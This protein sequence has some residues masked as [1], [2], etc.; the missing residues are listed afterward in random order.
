MDLLGTHWYLR[1]ANASESMFLQTGS[2]I[3]LLEFGYGIVE[4]LW[5]FIGL[6]LE[7]AP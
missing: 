7:E 2:A 4:G 6:L 1:E 5:G 3:D